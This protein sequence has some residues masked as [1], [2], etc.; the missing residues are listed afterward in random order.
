MKILQI[1]P[2]K[3]SVALRGFFIYIWL[4]VLSELSVTYTF[5][6]VYL[7]CAVTGIF[8]LYDN[9]KTG[10]VCTGVHRKI[11][12]GFS[13]LFSFAVVLANYPLF[14]PI[15]DLQNSFEAVCCLA[16]GFFLADSVLLYLLQRLPFPTAHREKK[17]PGLVFGFVFVSIVCIDLLYLFF[18]AYPGVLT[19]DSISTVAQVI[20][21]RAYNNT[22]PF[23]HTITVQLFMQPAL[24]V[25]GDIN[26][27]VAF[28]HIVQILFMAACFAYVVMTLHQADVPVWFLL[29]VYAVYAFQPH[30]IV[31]SVTMWK[32][33][34]F[35][36][37][38]VLFITAL[39]RLLKDIGKSRLCNYAVFI[40]GVFGF[41]LWRT[42]GWYAF[43]VTVLIMLFLLGKKEKRL[44]TVML[45]V[46]VFTWILINP[47]LDALGVSE[48]NLVEAFAVPMQ[49]IAKIIT[50]GR[51]LTPR[52]YEL[53]DRIFLLDKIPELYYPLTVDP[54]KFETFRYDQVPY[55]VEHSGEYLRLYISL[56]LRYPADY[57]KAWIEETKG[58]WNGGYYLLSYAKYVDSNPY[59]IVNAVEPNL[60]QKLFYIVFRVQ[61]NPAFPQPL[62][63]IGLHVWAL[64]SCTLL[65]VLKKRK[66]FLLGIPLLVLV[67]GLWI[68][69]PVFSEFRYAYPIILGM[70][71]ILGVTLF[72]NDDTRP[73]GS[74]QN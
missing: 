71:L 54:I 62:I 26:A 68:G 56:G 44:L 61:E 39:Y 9:Y 66:E 67:M 7:L 4:T 29:A 16:G 69:T 27:A 24:A 25:L 64:I 41:S 15:L 53:L 8:C 65:N 14:E 73:E 63:S 50:E 5:Y 30:N 31:F 45:F 58:Y 35:G 2:A 57:L 33:V 51:E 36:G 47:V 59:G 3:A 55:I 6:S 10:R 18:N 22:M 42:N 21:D 40:L 19:T 60:I 46:L 12:G 17:R 37:A 49:Q 13:F 20:G 52:E 38:A 23:W 43:L 28:F 70:P 74:A 32:D 1:N 34:P 48:T 11:L 72:H